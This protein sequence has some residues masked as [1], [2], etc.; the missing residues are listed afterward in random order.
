MDLERQRNARMKPVSIGKMAVVVFGLGIATRGEDVPKDQTQRGMNQT[1]REEFE[2]ADAKLNDLYKNVLGLQSDDDAKKKLKKAEKLWIQYRDAECESEADE[3][4]G[5][6]I[7]PMI[8]NQC[9]TQLTEARTKELQGR[10]D[11]LNSR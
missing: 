2:K 4:R 8:Y 10:L 6:S 5:G 7:A 1:A 3:Y 9:A 11:D